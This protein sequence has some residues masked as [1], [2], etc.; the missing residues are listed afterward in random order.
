MPDDAAF[1]SSTAVTAALA[2]MTPEARAAWRTADVPGRPSPAER[3]LDIPFPYGWY[4]ALLSD[5]LKIGE[6]KP[7][8]YFATDLVAWRGEDGTARML[9]AHCKHLGAHMGHGGRV[10]GNDLECPFH[11]WRYDGEGVV[12]DIPYAEAV[13]ARLRKP[14]ERQW[15]VVEANRMIWFW[16][17][18]H[19]AAPEWEVEHFPE[20]T[21]PDW[22]PY[23]IYEW[24]VYGS[25]QNMAENGVDVAHFQFVHGTATFP[26]SEMIWERTAT[27]TATSVA[28]W[29]T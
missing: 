24:N 4:P 15:P 18:P 11:A 7:L 13:P 26:T 12:H 28:A 10:S 16:Y 14:C 22:N 17:H 29:I 5:E 3:N 21:D 1:A 25:L 27:K 6:V 9:D 23:E 19:G 2:D 8:R 20:A